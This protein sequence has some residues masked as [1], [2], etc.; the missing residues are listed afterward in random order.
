MSIKAKKS[1]GQ[2]FLK[3]GAI[4][5]KIIIAGSVGKDDLVLEIGPGEGALTEKLL[6]KAKKVIAVEKDDRL[7][8]V[9][10]QKFAKNIENGSFELIHDDILESD[11]QKYGLKSEEYKLI[12][13][14][15]YYITG[16]IFRKFLSGPIQPNKMVVLV[17]KEV[18]QRAVARDEKESLLSISIKI[19]G[20]P[21]MMGVVARGNFNPVPNVDSA[22]LLVDNIS[23]DFF[24]GFTEDSFFEVL[25]AGFAH[26]RKQIAGNLKDL[27]KDGEKVST[28]LK[29]CDID[30]KS[31]AEDLNKEDWAKIVI[32]YGEI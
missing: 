22:I 27:I 15:P 20:E 9:L 32:E 6:E 18:A 25:K 26:K 10:E 16:Q 8:G 13:N 29:K 23:K 21:K 17:Q 7:I 28:L 14:I 1:L 24:A 19:Y 11:I 30:E 4:L 3:S 31:R 12:A 2:N 5:D